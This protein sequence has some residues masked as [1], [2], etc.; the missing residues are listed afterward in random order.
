MARGAY[1]AYVDSD[2]LW[3][4][5]YLRTMVSGLDDTPAVLVYCNQL[6]QLW[7]GSLDRPRLLASRIRRQQF[8]L[9]LLARENYLEPSA[10]VHRHPESLGVAGWDP[11]RVFGEDWEFFSRIVATSPE[12]VV[13][14]DQVL[15]VYRCAADAAGEMIIE[16]AGDWRCLPNLCAGE[17]RSQMIAA[18]PRL[19]SR[20]AKVPVPQPMSRTRRA[21]NSSARATYAS[22]SLRSGSSGS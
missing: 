13:H 5:D 20:H 10:V 14:I 11:D 12:Q 21:P 7:G 22:R 6:S 2:N 17:V 9:A 4:P 8:D 15:G 18:R 19:A 16:G 1:I 3:Y